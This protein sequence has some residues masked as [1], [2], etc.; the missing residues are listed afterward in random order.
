MTELFANINGL[1]ICYE[2]LGEGDPLLLVHGFGSKKE[3]WIAQFKP[4]S[5]HFRVI[6]FDNRG[7]GKSDRPKGDYTMEVF[8][9]DIAGLIDYLKIDKIHII[10][11]SLGGMIVQNFVL[12]Y[13]NRTNKMILINTNYGQPDES[14]AE[15]YKNMRLKELKL[16][17]EDPEKAFWQSTRAGYHIKFRKKLEA[18]PSKKWFGLWSAEDLIKDSMINPPTVEDIEVQAG[19][20]NTH[21]TYERLHEIKNESLLIASSHD[22]VMPVSVMTQMQERIPNSSLRVIDKAGHGSP[23]SRAPEINQMIISFLKN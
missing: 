8:A 12:K 19:A 9:D 2:I 16:K 17:E 14:G 6:R 22:R 5:E 13:P 3:S 1:N 7:A 11:W 21:H 23:R 4:L 15:V 20:A 10:G 18:E